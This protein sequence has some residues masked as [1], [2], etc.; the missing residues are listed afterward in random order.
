MEI[1]EGLKNDLK[2]VVWDYDIDETEL[3]AIFLGQTSTFSLNRDK[4]CAR[5]LLSTP[6]YRLLDHFGIK[7]LKEIL[8]DEAIR[9]IW[10]KD[11]RERF[12]YARSA[13]YGIS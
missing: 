13:L 3:V 7:G 5:L 10:V 6:W 8:T 9:Q 11:I 2:R 4:L 12:V 1:T